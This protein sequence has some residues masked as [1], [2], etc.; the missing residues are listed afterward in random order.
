MK[1]ALTFLVVTIIA[2]G[3]SGSLAQETDSTVVQELQTSAIATVPVVPP[4]TAT[5][6]DNQP[7]TQTNPQNQPSTVAVVVQESTTAGS[8]VTVA[9]LSLTFVVALAASLL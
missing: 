4:G 7:P 3:I 5:T 6:G 2:A 8:T 1:P 9:C